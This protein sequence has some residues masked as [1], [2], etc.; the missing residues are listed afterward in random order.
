MHHMIL[1]LMEKPVTPCF[2]SNIG[3]FIMVARAVGPQSSNKLNF[4][5]VSALIFSA[6]VQFE[7]K[8]LMLK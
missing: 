4:T 7:T 5:A 3:N 1:A 6:G 2:L 8:P